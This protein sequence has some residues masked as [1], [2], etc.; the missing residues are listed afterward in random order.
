MGRVSKVYNYY[1]TPSHTTASVG[2]ANVQVLAAN[3]SRTYAVII[4]DSLDNIYLAFG[5]TAIVNF[6]IKLTPDGNYE[7]SGLLGNLY[8]GQI[9]AIAES[10]ANNI[11]ITEGWGR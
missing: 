8:D 2:T 6:G 9:N 10:A 11:C 7:M 1:R 4:N 5:E 3:Q